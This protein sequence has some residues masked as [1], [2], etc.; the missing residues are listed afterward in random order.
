MSEHKELECI[1]EQLHGKELSSAHVGKQED[2]GRSITSCR[3]DDNKEPWWKKRPVHN[4][5]V[6]RW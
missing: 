3:Q 2:T 4:F 1:F 5:D 6:I